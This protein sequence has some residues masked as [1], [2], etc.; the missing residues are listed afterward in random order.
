MTS[1]NLK[2]K[3]FI[4]SCLV[5]LFI[6]VPH[7]SAACVNT[8]D[9]LNKVAQPFLTGT[10]PYEPHTQGMCIAENYIIWTRTSDSDS[11]ETTYVVLDIKTGNEVGHYT[12]H[13]GHS[14]S[15]TYNSKKKELA[16]VTDGYVY[17]FKFKDGELT[18]KDSFALS[19]HGCKVAYVSSKDYY[20]VSTGPRIF[21]TSDFKNLDLLFQIS[22]KGTNQGMGSDGENLY[23]IWYSPGDNKIEEYSLDGKKIRTL[24]IT[25]ESFSEIEEIDFQGGNM[26][27]NNTQSGTADGIYLVPAEHHFGKFKTV[28]K[29]TCLKDGKKERTCSGCGL[30]ESKVIPSIGHHTESDWIIKKEAACEEDGLKIKICTVCKKELK[31]EKIPATGHNFSEWKQI[32]EPTVFENGKEERICVY[33]HKQEYQEEPSLTP[34]ISLDNYNVEMAWYEKGYQLNWELEKGDYITDI[35]SQ[36]KKKATVTADGF[37]APKFPGKTDIIIK[38]KTGLVATCHVKI[39]LSSFT[40]F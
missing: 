26:Y 20:V 5:L 25:G 4:C 35:S 7:A 16:V 32:K 39:K 38:T 14:N 21:K 40:P 18:Q 3:L 17:L 11:S 1:F 15:L 13:T 33:C 37:I 22:E 24:S 10:T 19:V 23:I 12:F 27:L 28:Q 29:K 6:P 8:S 2:K 34:A 31:K 30:K 9:N 36:N